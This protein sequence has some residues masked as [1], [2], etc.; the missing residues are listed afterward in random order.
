MVIITQIQNNR[1]NISFKKIPLFK[2]KKNKIIKIWNKKQI[3]I[4]MYLI[5]ILKTHMNHK[6]LK[7]Y[8]NKNRQKVHFL[9]IFLVMRKKMIAQKIYIKI[10]F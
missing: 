4:T 5:H 7:I 2:I 6:N 10:Y 8:Y 1:I 3:I 9:M